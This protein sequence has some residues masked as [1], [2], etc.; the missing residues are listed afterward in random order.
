MKRN[1]LLFAT[2]LLV[3]MTGCKTH[4]FKKKPGLAMHLM[5]LPIN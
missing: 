4:R 3:G 1:S 2:A 5:P